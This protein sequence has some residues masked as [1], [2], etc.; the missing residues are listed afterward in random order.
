MPKA[1]CF[2]KDSFSHA[3]QCYKLT[4]AVAKGAEAAPF[5]FK[6]ARTT[7]LPRGAARIPYMVEYYPEEEEVD[8]EMP[9]R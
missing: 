9:E 3:L 5:L 8:E 4:G 6:M 7:V 2:E 1:Y